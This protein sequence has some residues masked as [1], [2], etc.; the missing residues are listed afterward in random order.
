MS[1]STTLEKPSKP[2]PEFPLFPHATKR[3]AKKIRG[4]HHY[5]GPWDDPEAA[6]KKYLDQKDEL[7]AGLPP[8]NTGDGLE[9]RDLCNRFLTNK[10]SRLGSGE[11][12]VRSFKN[13][14]GIC[15]KVV[16]FFGK[17]KL[18]K[19]LVADDFEAFRASLAKSLGAISLANRIGLVRM[20]F[21]FGF[22][23]GLISQP[24]RY[25]QSF[26][27]PSRRVLR[28]AR[29]QNG[30]KMFE[31]AEVLAILE[32]ADPILTAM[33]LLGINCGYG[34]TDV[35][36]LK[37]S[38]LNFETGWLDYPRGKTGVG[39]RCKLWLE[40]LSALKVAIELRPEPKDKADYDLCFVTP[41]GRKWV[42]L[43]SQS[44]PEFRSSMNVLSN[45][46]SNL[47]K[48][49]G[50]NHR[51]R[52]GFYTLRHVFATIG[53]EARDEQAVRSL[54]GHIDQSQLSAYQERISD[55][56]LISVTDCV[57]DWLFSETD[58]SGESE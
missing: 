57:R 33:T 23:N 34:N 52:L 39:R 22:D 31:S 53:S 14:F 27:K 10:R 37:Q 5:F 8:K 18:V 30:Q 46:F 19:D 41:D 40:T 29:N 51:K 16:E 44:D 4:K 11:I 43:G 20:V 48:K 32:A 56:R 25:G 45:K 17:N 3:W 28:V 15:S 47:L 54:M 55:E 36:N 12:E 1:K 6:L 7:H 9:I 50:I 21:K 38:S 35:A 49:L 58:S 2:Y 13:Y 24:I 26:D 42:R